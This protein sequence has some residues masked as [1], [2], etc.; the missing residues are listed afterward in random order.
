MTLNRPGTTHV[1]KALSRGKYR[2]K[3]LV[4][5]I[6]MLMSIYGKVRLGIP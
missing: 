3:D 2:P 4:E 5:P 1:L 6:K